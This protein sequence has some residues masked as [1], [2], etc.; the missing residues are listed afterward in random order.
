MSVTV[1]GAR[2]N[3]SW[4]T[5]LVWRATASG[6]LNFFAPQFDPILLLAVRFQFGSCY[7]VNKTKDGTGAGTQNETSGRILH[8][9]GEAPYRFSSRDNCLL[10][11]LS[12]ES[13]AGL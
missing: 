7:P 12:R 2:T 6:Q 9:N 5:V 4:C 8:T 10:G 11:I 1:S 13:A 3:H